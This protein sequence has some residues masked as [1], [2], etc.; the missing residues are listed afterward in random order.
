MDTVLLC[1]SV[2]LGMAASIVLANIGKRRWIRS[3]SAPFCVLWC[4]AA[5][6]CLDFIYS[7]LSGTGFSLL[8]KTGSALSFLLFIYVYVF[9]AAFG[10]MIIGCISLRSIALYI[11]RLFFSRF[12]GVFVAVFMV[13]NL[14]VALLGVSF[15][16]ERDEYDLRIS[17]ICPHNFNL[18]EDADGNFPDY[19][20]L[21]NAGDRPVLLSNFYLSDNGEEKMRFNLPAVKL[22]PGEYVIVWAD[23]SDEPLGADDSIHAS[24][25]LSDNETV[26]LSAVNGNIYDSVELGVLPYNVSATLVGDRYFS[27]YGTPG[28][29]NENC[30]LYV[31]PTLDAPKLSLESGF[32]TDDE[33]VLEISAKKGCSVYYTTDG[34]TPDINST[35]YTSPIKLTDVSAD[36]NK[37]VS[38]KNTVYDYDDAEISDDPVSKANVIRAVAVDGDGNVSESVCGTYFV[39]EVAR[40]YEGVCVLSVVSDPSGLFGDQ[41][42]CVTG[43]EYDHWYNNTDRET[44]AP[45]ANFM[46]H[47]KKWEREAV[48]QLWD[49]NGKMLLDQNCGIRVQG[50]SN[51]LYALKRFSFYARD[52]YSGAETFD[53]VI[54]ESGKE[55]RSFYTRTDEYDI[56]AQ[57]LVAD[58]EL[59]A[60]GARAVVCFVDGEFYTYTYLRER[61]DSTYF[62]QY[63]GVNDVAIVT[64]GELDEGSDEDLVDYYDLLDILTTGD[65]S[66]PQVYSLV[67][68]KMDVQSFIDFMVANIYCNNMDIGLQHNFKAWRSRESAGKG[69]NDGRWRFASYDMDGVGWSY[70]RTDSNITE[71]DAF[72]YTLADPEKYG[73][74]VT[75]WISIPFFGNLLKNE[76][77]RNQFIITYLDMMNTNYS[78]DSLGGMILEKYSKFGSWPWKP[79]MTDRKPY[80]L[81]HLKYA[82][83]IAGEYTEVTVNI[84]G[85][86]RVRVNTT[87]AE[88]DSGSWTGTYVSG[89][90]IV[91]TAEASDGWSFAG[92][93]G[94]ISSDDGT[95]TVTLG[96]EGIIANALFVRTGG[97]D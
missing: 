24:F 17:E 27:A 22:A 10:G 73:S 45:E 57:A 72:K 89:L 70:I 97:E 46:K 93:D 56:M 78:M 32:Y 37:Y 38:I 18:A 33:I 83:D 92:W 14:G 9:L 74:D 20:E 13:F 54:F 53:A 94:D 66:D 29:A 58:R 55:T 28:V 84:E 75:R 47:G 7:R 86:G 12:F 61:H 67:E 41:G 64:E 65:L 11:K 2:F 88:T 62:S 59:S 49:E 1:L 3:H 87:Y 51:R 40:A 85:K 50:N 81:E 5:Y 35:E 52:I 82:L 77:F 96:E 95:V 43:G 60:M 19:I 76:I 69:Y 26:I 8:P 36:P 16:Y 30:L 90:D 63:Y 91:L 39:G 23:G 44:A 34:S 21:Y 79:L 71:L 6:L 25:R 80:A 68:S 42:I 48:I 15:T 31:A 4:A